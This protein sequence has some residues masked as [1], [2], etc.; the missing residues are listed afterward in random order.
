MEPPATDRDDD[1]NFKEG[2]YHYNSLNLRSH[3]PNPSQARGESETALR[4]NPKTVG[5]QHREEPRELV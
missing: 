2:T 1:F 5:L 4:S 3:N